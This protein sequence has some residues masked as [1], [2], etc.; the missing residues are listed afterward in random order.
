[1]ATTDGEPESSNPICAR[2]PPVVQVGSRPL[3]VCW[4][5][6]LSFWNLHP[7]PLDTLDALVLR[8]DLLLRHSR[9][10]FHGARMGQAG[11]DLPSAGVL[12]RVY[13]DVLGLESA[14]PATHGRGRLVVAKAPWPPPLLYG[15][16]SVGFF[17]ATN[18]THFGSLCPRQ[19]FGARRS[20]RCARIRQLAGARF[21]KPAGRQT[22]LYQ[23][24]LN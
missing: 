15:L 24:W 10:V 9:E 6:T 1:M 18:S 17:A 2:A 19:K 12:N 3:S 7:F 14:S 11:S 13:I 4:M 22:Y 21:E 5:E 23:N 20:A 16:A 8:M